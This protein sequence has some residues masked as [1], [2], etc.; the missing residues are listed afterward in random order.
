PHLAGA[1]CSDEL[2]V[3]I[4]DHRTAESKMFP[5]PLA[6]FDRDPE[7]PCQNLSSVPASI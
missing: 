4:A 5:F 1:V 6:G 7:F 2:D 3:E